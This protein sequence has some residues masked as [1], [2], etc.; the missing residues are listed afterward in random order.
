VSLASDNATEKGIK[1]ETL[2][3]LMMGRADQR[4]KTTQTHTQ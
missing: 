3:M 4:R 2:M 1:R